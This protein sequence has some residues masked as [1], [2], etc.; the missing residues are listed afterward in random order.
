MKLVGSYLLFLYD[1]G[2]LSLQ[3]SQFPRQC[4]GSDWSEQ[5]MIIMAIATV[6]T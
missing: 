1:V 5:E 6:V 4:T 2:R 3:G